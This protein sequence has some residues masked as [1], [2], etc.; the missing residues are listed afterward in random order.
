MTGGEVGQPIAKKKWVLLGKQVKVT[1]Q[2]TMNQATAF[3][4]SHHT[5][6]TAPLLQGMF[7]RSPCLTY[8]YGALDTTPPPPKY[9][10]AT[11]FSAVCSTAF[12]TLGYLCLS[13][14]DV[15]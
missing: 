3:A 4:R 2:P 8:L 6:Y 15:W 14:G 13:V 12:F 1:S 9:G 11:Y 10:T 7:Q 5:E